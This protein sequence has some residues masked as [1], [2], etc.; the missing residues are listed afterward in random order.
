MKTATL[1]EAGHYY[2]AKGPTIWSNIGA[3]I[4]E[5]LK[6]QYEKAETMLFVDNVHGINDVSHH[7]VDHPV[8]P[9]VF[10]PNHIVYE[11]EMIEP[12]MELLEF[13]K[14]FPSKK[15]R[16]RQDRDGRWFT[17]GFAITKSN[18]KPSCVLLDA[19]LTVY[20]NKMGFPRTINVLPHFYKE[21]Q[22]NLTRI[23]KKVMPNDFEHKI[24]LFDHTGKYQYLDLKEGVSV[25]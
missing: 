1:I 8:V 20:K 13:L 18:G 24:V 11:S 7:E 4:A 17:S 5:T 9:L 25:S 23:L 10:T 21:Q 12:A 3:S 2:E 14:D 19:A 15:R 22:E 6:K 16:A